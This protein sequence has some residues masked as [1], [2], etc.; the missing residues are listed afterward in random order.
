MAATDEATQFES[1]FGLKGKVA[2]VL[3]GGLGH[4]ESVSKHLARAGC[5]VI[6][7]DIIAERAAR[8]AGDIRAMGRRAHEAVG[9]MCEPDQVDRVLAAAEADLGGVDIMVS[10][11]GEAAWVSFLDA[12]M[13]QWRG[14]LRRNLDYFFYCSQWV[15]RSMVRRGTGGRSAPSPRWTGCSPRRCT[16][17]MAWPRPG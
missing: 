15:A 12:T 7:A 6:V 11:I 13:E 10:I 14:D 4:G 17:L 1:V 3:G 8:V 5:D 2:L 9:D 16:P